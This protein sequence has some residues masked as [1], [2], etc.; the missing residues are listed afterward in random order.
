MP[1]ESTPSDFELKRMITGCQ[2]REKAL[3]DE[4][5]SLLA[6][7]FFP[8]GVGL[9]AVPA[10]NIEGS[11]RMFT[12]IGIITSAFLVSIKDVCRCIGER[13]EIFEKQSRIRQCLSEKPGD[14]WL[15]TFARRNGIHE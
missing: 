14:H 15:H 6:Q 5:H 11:L 8:A 13:F 2:K 9:I 10:L 1:L 12:T 3:R 4:V 7:V